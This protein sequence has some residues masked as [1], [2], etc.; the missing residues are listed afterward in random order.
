MHIFVLAILHL[1]VIRLSGQATTISIE[2]ECLKASMA[3]QIGLSSLLLR[4]LLFSL[5]RPSGLLSVFAM[6]DYLDAI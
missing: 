5:A 4:V 2:R 3:R 6:L 1:A